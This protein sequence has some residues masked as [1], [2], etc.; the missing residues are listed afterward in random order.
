MKIRQGFVSNSSSTSFTFL[1]KTNDLNEAM[2]TLRK[3]KNRF[4]LAEPEG[5]YDANI[6]ARINGHDVID[7]IEE[8]VDNLYSIDE[9]ISERK[10]EFEAFKDDYHGI[11]S[12]I[13]R[14]LS[15]IIANLEDVKENGFIYLF[16]INFG[17]NEGDISGGEIGNIM[18]YKGRDVKISECDLVMFTEQ[19][20]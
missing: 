18:D 12:Q 3:Y 17:D 15:H 7:C 5:L 6:S 4:D 14:E 13:K 1:F 20:R 2:R 8:N 9:L 10:E 19:D 11:G 16:T